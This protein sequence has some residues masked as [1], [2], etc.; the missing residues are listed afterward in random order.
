[1]WF[2]TKIQ[3]KQ[4]NRLLQEI[5]LIYITHIKGCRGGANAQ[6]PTALAAAWKR[7]AEWGGSCQTGWAGGSVLGVKRKS[8]GRRGRTVLRNREEQWVM[9]SPLPP[10]S[11]R[12]FFCLVPTLPG[13]CCDSGWNCGGWQHTSALAELQLCFRGE[14]ASV[15]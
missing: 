10:A 1:M 8:T 3:R 5:I 11:P 2:S 7:R 15:G 14:N 9:I 6:A 4:L 13:P 12:T